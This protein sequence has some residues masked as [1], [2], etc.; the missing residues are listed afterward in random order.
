MNHA[1]WLSLLASGSLAAATW[2]AG[3]SARLRPLIVPRRT[4]RGR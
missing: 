4:R 2:M 1:V 3:R